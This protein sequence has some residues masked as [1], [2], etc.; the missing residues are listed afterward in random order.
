MLLVHVHFQKNPKIQHLVFY[1]SL[2]P[3]LNHVL[4][5]F[6]DQL[7]TLIGNPVLSFQTH[8]ESAA[9]NVCSYS[10]LQNHLCL[11]N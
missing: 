10:T 8:I 5:L 3:V 2:P 6:Q 9:H 11:T 1:L 7:G 4:N